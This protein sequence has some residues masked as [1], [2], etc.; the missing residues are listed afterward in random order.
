MKIGMVCYPT[1]GGSGVVATELGKALAA[2]GHE[3]HFI[4]YDI[5]FRLDHFQRNVF[6]HQVRP[7]PYPVF[8]F[9][10]YESALTGKIVDV[11]Q[12]AKLDLIHVH[13]AIPHASA[14]VLAREIVGRKLPV[15]TTL[16]GTDITLVGKEAAYE[17]VVTYAIN[18]SDAVTAVSDYLRRA[19]YENFSINREIVVIPN[20]ID[21]RRFRPSFEPGAEEKRFERRCFTGD[22]PAA[23]IVMHV[24]NFRRVKRTEDVFDAFELARKRMERPLHLVLVG[25][26]P[27]RGALE[28]KVRKHNAQDV[29]HFLGRQEAVEELLPRADVFVMPSETESF[30]L[31]ALEAMA[32]GVPVVATNVGGLPEVVENGKE[33]F[34]C[35][36]GDVEAMADAIIKILDCD[37][38]SCGYSQA[39]REKA[40]FFAQEKIVPMYENLYAWLVE[41]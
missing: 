39:A 13:Y 30:G 28:R 9:L 2:E 38:R 34:L 16:H 20:F 26:G 11:A 21:P 18:R 4:A 32:C 19:T 25:D 17:P 8:D 1:Y 40:L 31:S 22:D 29:V 15:V 3:I 27:E 12:T 41:S 23:R 33:G 37:I 10:P 5:P 6:V 36:V 35:D 24:S 14:A 7:Q